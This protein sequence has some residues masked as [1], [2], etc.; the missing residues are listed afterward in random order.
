[1]QEH[2]NPERIDCAFCHAEM[3]EFFVVDIVNACNDDTISVKLCIPCC[4]SLTKAIGVGLEVGAE[5]T[6]LLGDNGV[7]H[8]IP[9]DNN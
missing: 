2:S 4:E 8:G 3:E 1:M 6:F 7:L 5:G 9:N